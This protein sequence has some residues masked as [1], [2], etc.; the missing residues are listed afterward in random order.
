MILYTRQVLN[1]RRKAEIAILYARRVLNTRR[2]A[3]IAIL[4]ARRVLNPRQKSRD[5]DSLRTAGAQS[6]PKSSVTIWWTRHVANAAPAVWSR[7]AEATRIVAMHSGWTSMSHHVSS[8]RCCMKWF[9]C[10]LC[11]SGCTRSKFLVLFSPP[12]LSPLRIPPNWGSNCIFFFLV[13]SKQ[14]FAKF[15]Y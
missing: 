3:E 9:L 15:F 8:A 1:P 11:W 5:R 14:I 12:Q 2:K 10:T 6:S 13:C 4:Y 7:P